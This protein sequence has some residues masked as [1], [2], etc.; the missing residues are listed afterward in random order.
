MAKANTA[1]KNDYQDLLAG[2]PAQR[3]AVRRKTNGPGRPS[4]YTEAIVDTI[5]QSMAN[6][7]TVTEICKRPDMPGIETIQ[8]WKREKPEFG[9]RYAQAREELADWHFNEALQ[10]TLDAT[11]ET[12]QVARLRFEGHKW[13]AEKLNPREYGQQKHQIELTGQVTLASMVESSLKAIE[14]SI[15]EHDASETPADTAA[16]E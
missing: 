4:I 14:S 7:E 13:Y 16:K 10:V 15:I 5:C 12:V 6:G 11:I 2:L 8:R 1:L 3:E 9:E